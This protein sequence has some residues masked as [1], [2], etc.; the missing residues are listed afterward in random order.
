MRSITHRH[1]SSVNTNIEL[2]MCS[3]CHYI[4]TYIL[5]AVWLSFFLLVCFCLVF[6]SSI[7]HLTQIY[8]L[9]NQGQMYEYKN[10]YNVLQ[11]G[12]PLSPFSLFLS[13]YISLSFYICIRLSVCLSLPF[14]HTHTHTT[15]ITLDLS[16]LISPISC[17][18]SHIFLQHLIFSS[19]IKV[20]SV[21]YL[22][23]FFF[24]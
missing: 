13:I 2:K 5:V 21:S 15:Y 18:L 17:T 19:Q 9:L 11:I 22:S 16:S 1:V 4:T 8:Q 7:T 3:V 6:L 24:T 20:A 23:L 12:I 10:K 14:S